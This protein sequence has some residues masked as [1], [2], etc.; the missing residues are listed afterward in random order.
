MEANEGSS[1]PPPSIKSLLQLSLAFSSARRSASKVGIPEGTSTRVP[2]MVLWTVLEGHT[3]GACRI[4]W[5]WFERFTKSEGTDGAVY[6]MAKIKILELCNALLRRLSLVQNT[7]FAGQ[8]RLFLSRAFDLTERSAMNVGGKKNLE[9]RTDFQ[10][11]EE[12]MNEL[13]LKTTSGILPAGSSSESDV[14]RLPMTEER[15]EGLVADDAAET[16]QEEAAPGPVQHQQSPDE[17]PVDYSLYRAFWGMQKKIQEPEWC[18]S[19]PEMWKNFV[20]N[21]DKVLSAFEGNDFSEHDILLAREHWGA[22]KD[23]R[24]QK[25]NNIMSKAS[26]KEEDQQQLS[27]K[28]MEIDENEAQPGPD[29]MSSCLSL[30]EGKRRRGGDFQQH[31]GVFFVCKY[32]TNSRLLRLQLRDPTLRLQLLAQLMSMS[33]VIS[34]ELHKEKKPPADDGGNAAKEALDRKQTLSQLVG[35][36]KRL[37]QRTPPRG[38]EFLALEVKTLQRNASWVSWKVGGCKAS[39]EKKP[40]DPF[41]PRDNKSLYKIYPDA[42]RARVFGNVDSKESLDSI[43]RSL[44]DRV[45]SSSAHL[46][47]LYDCLEPDSG[48][49]VC[50]CERDDKYGSVSIKPHPL[51]LYVNYFY[52]VQYLLVLLP[53]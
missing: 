37:I 16:S 50:V 25:N 51:Y 38:K 15:E 48:V 17:F 20:T 9:N 12:F 46:Q 8:I 39:L 10:D 52:S 13:E 28:S 44:H 18:L 22:I 26:E 11:E 35:R 27:L 47:F 33:C 23:E 14:Q 53:L 40:C 3:I 7:E 19:T 29:D 30:S 42:K 5:S 6:K 45:P 34:K 4:V 43:C 2:F 32:L 31:D 24:G 49:S 1:L 41:P 36:M 21:T